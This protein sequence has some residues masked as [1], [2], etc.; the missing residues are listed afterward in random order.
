MGGMFG[1][2]SNLT[3]LDVSSWDTSSLVDKEFMFEGTKWEEDP[4][5]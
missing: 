5:I 2:C 3:D 4:P 1:Y